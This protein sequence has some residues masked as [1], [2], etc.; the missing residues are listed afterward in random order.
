MP[1]TILLQLTKPFVSTAFQ[2]ISSITQF[3]ASAALL[4]LQDN[5]DWTKNREDDLD[6][7]PTSPNSDSVSSKREQSSVFLTVVD[8]DD[9]NAFTRMTDFESIALEGI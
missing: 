2:S 5:S 6:G 7:V 4:K 8:C 1:K 3:E 9:P